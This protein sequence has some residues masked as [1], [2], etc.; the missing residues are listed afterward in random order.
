M[1]MIKKNLNID[2]TKISY[3]KTGKGKP[4][5]L[6]S[7]LSCDCDLWKDVIPYLDKYYTVYAFSLPL[8][9]SRNKNRQQYTVRTLHYFLDK[10]IK[11]FK[12]KKP[13]LIGQSLGSLI[14]MKYTA[15]Y[16]KN[17]EKLI[18]ISSPLTDKLE[19]APIVWRKAVDLV[20]K[21]KTIDT[22]V[23]YIINNENFLKTL[24]KIIV[25]NSGTKKFSDGAAEFIKS[26]PIKSLAMC[27]K[28]L[29][30]LSF[31]N[32]L[33]KIKI[34]T[35]FVYGKKDDILLRFH[36]T[37]L[38]SAVSGAKIIGLPSE[39]FIPTELPKRLS[40]LI[41]SFIKETKTV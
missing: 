22:I 12:I 33:K 10:L 19:N 26:I 4:I 35:L 13:I 16:P 29:F 18:M 39:H 40:R 41:I 9:G 11:K 24:V 5:V 2:G 20:L 6:L 32:D 15:K 38:Y 17:V 31:H 30:E 27:Y 28:D 23:E 8:Y 1:S 37:A 34:P 7:S 3:I 36:G 14:E 25:P 21:S